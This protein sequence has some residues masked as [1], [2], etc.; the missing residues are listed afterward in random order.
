MSQGVMGGGGDAKS[1]ELQL[2]RLQEGEPGERKAENHKGSG[3]GLCLVVEA[4]QNT[5][6]FYCTK[7]GTEVMETI[8]LLPWDITLRWGGLLSQAWQAQRMS[9][10][11]AFFSADGNMNLKLGTAVYLHISTYFLIALCFIY[12]AF[13]LRPYKLYRHHLSHAPKRLV[14]SWSYSPHLF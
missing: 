12:S 9:L 10:T 14:S 2:M 5:Q 7:G 6:V 4:V 1:W 13:P 3:P 8:G 11:R